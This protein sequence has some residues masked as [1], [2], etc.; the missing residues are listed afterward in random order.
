MSVASIITLRGRK[1]I[2][3]NWWLRSF[4]VQIS[5]VATTRRSPNDQKDQR[6]LDGMQRTTGFQNTRLR[7]IASLDLQKRKVSQS[8]SR[9][10]L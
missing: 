6:V 9:T 3:I 10:S 8:K 7:A 4:P 1:A 5:Q 2:S